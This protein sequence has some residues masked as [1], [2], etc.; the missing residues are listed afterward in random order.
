MSLVKSHKF[1]K[2]SPHYLTNRNE[3]DTLIEWAV[4]GFVLLVGLID[5]VITI[6]GRLE[7]VK[8][9]DKVIT[10]SRYWS[11]WSLVRHTSEQ[12]TVG[13]SA[14]IAGHYLLLN[15]FAS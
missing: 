10:L 15:I 12:V 5:L 9:Y 11:K 14:H 1:H 8:G 6:V 7:I 3:I 4:H 2:S 13:Y